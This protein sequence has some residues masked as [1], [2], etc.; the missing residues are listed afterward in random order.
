M[1]HAVD[2]DGLAG[3]HRAAGDENGGGD[4]ETE[5]CVEHARGGDLVAIGDA[6][7]GIGSV[8]V[9]HVSMESE[10]ISRDGSE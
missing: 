2:D 6:H 5:C 1:C 4:V 10:M 3:L 8:R 9:D 7:E